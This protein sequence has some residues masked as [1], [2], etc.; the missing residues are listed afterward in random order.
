MKI[1]GISGSPVKNSNTDRLVKMILEKT[2]ADYEFIKLSDYEL[3]PC[4]ACLGCVTD[5]VCK[6]EDDW[7]K[8]APLILEAKGFV[9]GSYA[10]YNV[11]D[12][13]TK[14]FME[15]MYSFRHQK[16][17]NK[18]KFVIAVAV[19]VKESGSAE[20]AVDQVSNFARLEEMNLIGRITADG[21][22]TCLSCGLGEVCEI[23]DVKRMYGSDA[24]IT[25]DMFTKVEDQ[26]SV[27]SEA[28]GKAL[29][30]ADRLN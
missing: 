27:I 9:I 11:I 10:P 30:M 1:L 15:R 17:L 23:S 13:N 5:N 21:N 28:Y 20:A 29:E 18:G 19:G 22:V 6:Q 16:L 8:I 2:G 3:H 4:Q 26:E 12:A 25:S 14:M 7:Q 24:K